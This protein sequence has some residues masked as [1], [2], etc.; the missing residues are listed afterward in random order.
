MTTRRYHKANPQANFFEIVLGEGSGVICCEWRFL[1][2]L[3]HCMIFISR[4]YI[5]V[6]C[7]GLIAWCSACSTMH[8]EFKASSN[9]DVIQGTGGEMHPAGNGIEVYTVGSPARK[10][11]V[12]GTVEMARSKQPHPGFLRDLTAG[13]LK[14][15]PDMEDALVEQAKKQGG[16]AVILAPPERVAGA[17]N[18]DAGFAAPEIQWRHTKAYVLQF[19]N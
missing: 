5:M 16:N 19:V 10:Y 15:D 2:G 12:V 13:S 18:P 1:I 11:R 3:N 9:A 14:S 8:P 7:A 17:A 6:W 4:I